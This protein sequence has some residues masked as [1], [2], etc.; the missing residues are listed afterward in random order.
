[1]YSCFPVSV[2]IR[3]A[4]LGGASLP[5]CIVAISTISRLANYHEMGFL[6]VHHALILKLLT[7]GDLSSN[8]LPNFYL[9]S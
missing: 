4:S 2:T 7:Q 6:V 5:R 3:A 9:R 8:A 1:M